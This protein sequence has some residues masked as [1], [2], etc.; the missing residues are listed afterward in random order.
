MRSSGSVRELDVVKLE[1]N[2]LQSGGPTHYTGIS[3]ALET[4]GFRASFKRWPPVLQH[5]ASFAISHA[6]RILS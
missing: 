5:A 6:W 2:Q 4:P 1:A 3:W